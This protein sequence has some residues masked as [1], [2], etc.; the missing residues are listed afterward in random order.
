[1]DKTVDVIIPLYNGAPYIRETLDSVL[2]QTLKP[3]KITVVDDGSTDDSVK[4]VYNRPDHSLMKGRGKKLLHTQ[5]AKTLPCLNKEHKITR[6]SIVLI[7]NQDVIPRTYNTYERSKMKIVFY[8]LISLLIL[9]IV[10]WI[11]RITRSNKYMRKYKEYHRK[12]FEA[13]RNKMIIIIP[14]LDETNRIEETVERCFEIPCK[15]IEVVISTTEKEF[16]RFNQNSEQLKEKLTQLDEESEL[17]EFAIK[18]GDKH[19]IADGVGFSIE[20]LRKRCFELIESRENTVDVVD[21]LKKKYERLKSYHSV[22]SG[23]MGHQLNYAITCLRNEEDLAE[24]VLIGIYN[25]DSVVDS[26]VLCWISDVYNQI[27][28]KMVIFQQYGI[29]NKNISECNDMPLFP[30]GIL[31]SNMLWQ[32]RWSVGFEM[33]HA[34][35]GLGKFKSFEDWTEQFLRRDIYFLN[36]CI[37]HGLFFNIQVYDRIG[38]FEERTLNE[39]AAFGLNA[40]LK[41][42]PILPVPF[43]EKADSPNTV[44]SLYKQKIAWFFGPAQT[45]LY[46]RFVKESDEL[47]SKEKRR[48]FWLCIQLFEHAIRWVAVPVQILSLFLISFFISPLCTVGVIAV[49]IVY[50]GVINLYCNHYFQKEDKLEAKQKLLVLA[51]CIPQFLLHGLSG[52]VAM[53]KLIGKT[54]IGSKIT[55]EK[56]E[57]K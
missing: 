56:T 15:N 8:L 12:P 22:E 37:G 13:I 38:G 2:A 57:M 43:L 30:A 32:T 28:N 25:A 45:F 47:S 40:C 51:G 54:V 27:S 35:M 16:E 34:L 53:I 7:T 10:C 24:D 41:N 33:A 5:F 20:T 31:L 4:L 26:K 49:S 44:K 19:W 14:V 11:C 42:I 21:K 39:D 18:L 17:K 46:F 1:M 52:I 36:Y 6:K 9:N 3:N 50:T 23:N 48:L 55:K 29:Y